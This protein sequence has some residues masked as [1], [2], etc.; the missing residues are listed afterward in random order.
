LEY[1]FWGPA[2]E[3]VLQINFVRFSLIHRINRLKT[4]SPEVGASLFV[5]TNGSL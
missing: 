1:A 2:L 4:P 5:S 3:L